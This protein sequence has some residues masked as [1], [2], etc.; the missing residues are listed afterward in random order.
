MPR[1]DCSH[2]APTWGQAHPEG[3]RPVDV[4]AVVGANRYKGNEQQKKTDVQ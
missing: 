2:G 4:C 3:L 1:E